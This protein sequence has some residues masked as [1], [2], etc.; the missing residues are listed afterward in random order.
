M[1]KIKTAQFFSTI[2]AMPSGP[3]F[4]LLSNDNSANLTSES[5]TFVLEISEIGV[6]IKFKGLAVVSVHT[7]LKYDSNHLQIIEVSAEDPLLNDMHFGNPVVLC[8]SLIYT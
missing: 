7:D 8:F 4:T 2:E 5:V 6:L 1:E 3:N